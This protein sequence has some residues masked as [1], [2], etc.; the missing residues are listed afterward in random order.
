MPNEK[1]KYT[2]IL[3]MQ[4][5]SWEVV[6]LTPPE[7]QRADGPPILINKSH[8]DFD[9]NLWESI[10]ERYSNFADWRWDEVYLADL[11]NFD[12]EVMA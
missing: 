7:G 9:P 10:K 3:L 4:D 2:P 8:E 12:E 5:D 1:T 6:L 11:K